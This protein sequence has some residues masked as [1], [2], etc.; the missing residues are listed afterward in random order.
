MSPQQDLTALRAQVSA[1]E[2][3][4][5]AAQTRLARAREAIERLRATGAG[6]A[7]A[8]AEELEAAGAAAKQAASALEDAR[9]SLLE[10]L[11]GHIGDLSA[12]AT[13]A[14]AS[15]PVALLPIGLETRFDGDTLLIRVLPDEVHVED[16][17]PELS[18]S[19]VEAGR[20][21]WTQA[22]RGGTAEPGAT[23]AERASW[24]RLERAVG[25]STRAAWVAEQ[26]TPT[27]GARPQVPVAAGEELP[28]PPT[29]GEPPRRAGA[30]S[31]AAFARTLPDRFVAIAYRRTGSGG[32]ASWAEIG[33]GVG[34]PVS[35]SVQ[36][37]FDPAAPA[38]EI[39]ADGPSL[40]DGMRWMVDPAAAD[41]AG[42]LIRVELPAGAQRVD[43][44]VVLGV[45]G[46]LEPADAAARLGDLLRNHHYSRGLELLRV[47]TPTNNTRAERSG[48][49]GAGDPSASFAVERR[50]PTPPDGSDGALLA[51]ALGIS[52][53]ILRGV[54]N[55]GDAEQIAAGHMN[56]LVWPSAFGYW[57]DSLVQPGP[58]DSDIAD[59]RWHALQ[60]VR[61]RGPLPTLRVG[62]QPYGVL[63]VTSLRDWTAGGEPAGVVRTVHFLQA[64]L[65]WWLDGVA[66]APVVRAGASPDQGMLDVLAQA[67]VSTTVA[68][69][70]MVGAN[71]CYIPHAVV[72][73]LHGPAEEASRQR[74]LALLGFRSLGITGFPYVGQLVGRPDPVPLLHLPYTVDPR[75]PPDQ[76][77]AAWDAIATYLRNLR[78]RRTRDLQAENPSGFTSLLTL[79]AKRS[80][81]LERVRAGLLDTKGVVAGTLVEAHLRVDQAPVLEAQLLSTTATLRIGETRSTAGAFL[82]GAVKQDDG[83]T[84]AV[85]D[86]LDQ[87]LVT[88]TLDVVTHAD[89]AAT[90]GAAEAVAALAP[91]RA[92]LLLGEALDVAS[93]RFDA[94]VTS[95]ATR[96]LSDLR[97][98]MPVGV[99]L[100]AYGVVEDLVRR[101]PRPAVEQPP[102]N[103]PTPLVQDTSGGGYVHAPS[104]GQAATA[105]VLRAGHLSHA[106]RDPNAAALAVDLSSSRV[107]AALALLEGVRLGQ[108][109]GALLGY[110]T[111]RLLH[112]AGAHVAVEV[113]RTLAPPPV[114]TAV[115]TPEGLPPR[116]VCDGLAL[117]RMPRNQVLDAVRAADASTTDAVGS[118]LDALAESVDAVADLL[119]AESVHQIVRG[120]PTRAAAALDALNRGEGAIEEPQVVATPRTG[121]SITNR[122][123]VLVGEE[124]PAAP[125]WPTGGVR[126]TVEPRLA[127]WAGHVLGDPSGIEIT[128][129]AGDGSAAIPL[130]DLGLGALDVVYEPLAPRVLRHARGVGVPEGATVDVSEPAVGRLLAAAEGVHGLFARARAGDGLDLAR[131]QDRGGVIT[132]PPPIEG[133]TGEAATALTTT[134]P[135]A[136]AG[137]RRA[138]LDAARAQLQQVIGALAGVDP[139]GAPP[140]EAD[141]RVPLDTLAAFGIAPGGDPAQ[142]PAAAALAAVRDAASARLAQSQAAP[143]DDDALFG[144]GFHVLPLAAPPFP[145]VLAAALAADPCAATPDAALAPLG[146]R[147][148][149]LTS[150]LETHGRV[151]AGAGRLA[152]VLLAS[153]LRRSGGPARLRAFQQPPEPFPD[154]DAPRRGQW[155]G[156]TFPARLGPDPVTHTVAHVLGDLDA[157][158]GM[159][160]LAVDEFVEVVPSPATTTALSF[161]FDAP[162]ARPPQT[163]L[164]AVPPAPGTPWTVDGLVRVIGETLD[165]AKVRMVDLSAVAWAGRFVPTIYLTEGDVAGGLD[166]PM[167]ELV[168]LANARMEATIHP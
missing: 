135:D 58:S 36:L 10:V 45:L 78:G 2:D 90:V 5:V 41:D 109:L 8:A 6:D 66:H 59:M 17:E 161:G 3:A 68:V 142:A 137:A 18:D 132:G 32:Q 69:R 72:D 124:P 107:R 23:D 140:A 65:P 111:E 20:E 149:A 14:P 151:R 106:A 96:R 113:V 144:E 73:G 117:S 101:E 92:A 138:R 116:A 148:G 85:A 105:A 160:V 27:G 43:R 164:L 48:F 158:R 162:G 70:S 118:V 133:A 33:R 163:I 34:K 165:L 97:A 56:A 64:A 24:A 102:A 141:I 11:A 114:V 108:S 127:A 88:G 26:T 50:T 12:S 94:W 21:F 53:D 128:V 51:R 9:G 44:L 115:G 79:L 31:R 60:N 81:M 30:W 100:G 75:T 28:D 57:F 95:L 40:P 80:V 25:T 130:A 110:R 120:N 1:G 86:H 112:E 122:V 119:L 156:V 152:D 93:H 29:F 49:S 159:A 121:T 134:L 52:A 146:G 87:R 15:V 13:I 91:D 42:L 84:L 39:D 62:R 74:W 16:H 46:S 61:G 99:T 98:A 125:G 37:G 131:P 76:V 47:G 4:N 166:L 19:E 168:S 104:L 54:A 145:A 38:P 167:R 103:A 126:A 7:A 71:V 63:P 123:L 83:T 89:Y 143:D 35:D 147:A 153:R 157:E 22:W 136:D 155:L 154:A 67:P 77:A 82:A 139:D 55:S 129:R 150:W